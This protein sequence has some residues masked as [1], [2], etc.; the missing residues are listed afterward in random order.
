LVLL[1]PLLSEGEGPATGNSRIRIADI[2]LGIALDLVEADLH[3]RCRRLK[4]PQRDARAGD[5]Y[6]FR[7]FLLCESIGGCKEQRQ[8]P[9]RS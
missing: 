6:R 1:M 2:H 5:N 8:R 9:R 7:I 3:H 4:A